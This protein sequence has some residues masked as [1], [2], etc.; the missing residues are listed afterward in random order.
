MTTTQFLGSPKTCSLTTMDLLGWGPTNFPIVEAWRGLVLLA[1]S[2]SCFVLKENMQKWYVHKNSD[3]VMVRLFHGFQ[4]SVF[5]WR[6]F[7]FQ[8]CSRLACMASEGFMAHMDL[9]PVVALP[10]PPQYTNPL[11]KC[12]SGKHGVF[13]M[14]LKDW[15]K[16][17]AAQ[18]RCHP[19]S[20]TVRS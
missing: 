3:L 19:C 11:W 18:I 8:H 20:I 6:D 7:R 1:A 14:W 5:V 2:P 9:H 12:Q 17:P 15:V 10:L 4:V 13:G 16:A